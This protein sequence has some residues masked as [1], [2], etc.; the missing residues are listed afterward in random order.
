[1]ERHGRVR[2]ERIQHVLFVVL[3]GEREQHAGFA[4]FQHELVEAAA[5]RFPGAWSPFPS[6]LADPP[7]PAVRYAVGGVPIA[8][9]MILV[10]DDLNNNRVMDLASGDSL[11]GILNSTVVW[12]GEGGDGMFL[13]VNPATAAE[14]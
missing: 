13:L 9:A 4:L 1:M 5:R 2:R 7:G 8:V 6:T 10:Y 12:R 11:R 14:I 3:A